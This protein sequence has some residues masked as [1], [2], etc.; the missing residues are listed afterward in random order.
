MLKLYI[1]YC[2]DILSAEDGNRAN[3]QNVDWLYE[4]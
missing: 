2:V 3:S 4:I 1:S